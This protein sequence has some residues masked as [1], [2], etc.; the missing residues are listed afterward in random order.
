MDHETKISISELLEKLRPQLGASRIEDAEGL[1]RVQVQFIELCAGEV[2]ELIFHPD[3]PVLG[4]TVLNVKV[5]SAL[6]VAPDFFA[7]SNVRFSNS[8]P[9]LR[10]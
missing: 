5:I 2:G 10:P 6:L 3:T 4:A 1:L 9:M 8:L 7:C